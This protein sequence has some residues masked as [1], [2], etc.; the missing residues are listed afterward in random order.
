MNDVNEKLLNDR[1]AAEILGLAV[2]TLRNWRNNGRG[3]VYRKMGRA[4]R[5]A[6]ADLQAFINESKR[7]PYL[8]RD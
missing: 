4:V 6:L 1:Q 5:Y 8:R 2:S 3:P 7:T